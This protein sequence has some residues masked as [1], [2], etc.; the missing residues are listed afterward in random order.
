ME[1]QEENKENKEEDELGKC[2]TE[3]EEYLAGWQR[4]KADF[5]NY[6]KEEAKRFEDLARFMTSSVLAD[7]LPVLD[8][9]DLA[10]SGGA[11]QNSGSDERGM[12]LIRA[13]FEDILKKRGLE[14]I[15]AVPGEPFDPEKHESVGELESEHS[16][17]SVAEVVQRGYTF[18]GRVLR[19]VRVRI[20][21]NKEE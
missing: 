16:A 8:S 13:Q 15:A 19:P 9:F 12:L 4:A 18:Q 7:L 14:E 11:A 10:F 20:T 6:R 2:R 17:G 3:R 21:K 5:I 1:E